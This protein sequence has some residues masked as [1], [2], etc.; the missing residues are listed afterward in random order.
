MIQAGE[1]EVLGKRRGAGVEG[2]DPGVA[3][4]SAPAGAQSS[5]R[6]PRPGANHPEC[7]VSVAAGLQGR[8]GDR[9]VLSSS[10]PHGG[11]PFGL[12]SEGQR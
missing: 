7:C 2:G 4:A 10:A 1:G 6:H 5:R 11:V 12:D 9:S 3:S 8:G